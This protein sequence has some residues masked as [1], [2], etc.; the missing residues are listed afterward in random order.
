MPVAEEL[1][2]LLPDPAS[3]RPARFQRLLDPCSHSQRAC[4]M[5]QAPCSPR[6]R[7]SVRTNANGKGSQ[8]DADVHAQ[9]RTPYYKNRRLNIPPAFKTDTSAH[10]PAAPGLCMPCSG[11]GVCACLL[12]SAPPFAVAAAAAAAAVA[13]L[14]RN[15]LG[16][17]WCSD[18]AAGW[19]LGAVLGY[20]WGRTDPYGALLRKGSIA[21]SGSSAASV[22]AVFVAALLCVRRVV[23]PV[24]PDVRAVWFDNAIASLPHDAREAYAAAGPDGERHGKPIFRPRSLSAKVPMVAT[25]CCTLAL[26]GFYPLLLPLVSLEPS[27]PR[28]AQAAVGLGGLVVLRG[29]SRALRRGLRVEPSTHK[30]AYFKALTFVAVCSWTLL[31]SQATLTPTSPRTYMPKRTYSHKHKRPYAACYIRTQ[32]HAPART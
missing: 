10:S 14:T 5:A 9:A 31:F 26:T 21:V 3:A 16:V 24:R 30:A 25:L 27:R 4:L 28:M 17:H 2:P 15:L 1:L 19:V 32:T 6:R 20:V 13:G 18:T 12:A 8:R 22:T 29:A 7:S 11:L 23:A